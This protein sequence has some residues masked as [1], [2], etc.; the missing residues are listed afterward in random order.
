MVQGLF[1]MP[2]IEQ[3]DPE[4][5]QEDADDEEAGLEAVR[6]RSHAGEKNKM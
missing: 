4:R 5:A 3:A 1:F 2:V 6:G